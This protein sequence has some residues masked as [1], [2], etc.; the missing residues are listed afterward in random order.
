ML[1]LIAMS[2]GLA[3]LSSGA[4]WAS[5]DTTNLKAELQS[6]LQRSIDRSLIDG[7]FQRVN[8]ETGDIEE[9]FPVDVHAMI[10]TMGDTYVMCSDLKTPDGKSVTVDYYLAQKGNRYVVFQTEIDNRAPLKSLMKSGAATR[11]K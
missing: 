4:L 1:K 6:G 9:Y 3:V 11:L 10:L 8:M 5:D 7:A 2:A